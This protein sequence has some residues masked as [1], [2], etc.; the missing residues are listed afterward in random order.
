M[1]VIIIAVMVSCL[2]IHVKTH[3]ILHFKYVQFIECQLYLKNIVKM[4]NR[5]RESKREKQRKRQKERQKDKERQREANLKY[6][7]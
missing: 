4:K 3:P 6:L 1:N 5:L 7:A 2:Y